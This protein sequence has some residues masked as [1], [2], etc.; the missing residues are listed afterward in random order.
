MNYLVVTKCRRRRRGV[1]GLHYWLEICMQTIILVSLHYIKYLI[2]F[3]KKSFFYQIHIEPH[4]VLLLEQISFYTT[5][6][7]S[8]IEDHQLTK[9]AW[10]FQ[11]QDRSCLNKMTSSNLAVVFGP[12]LASPPSGQMSLQAIAPINAFT[13][14]LLE[15]QESIFII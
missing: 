3:W 9:Y 6:R 11:V 2:L 15:N 14:F 5:N 1:L 7:Y 4:H 13:D 12:N 10:C 8:H